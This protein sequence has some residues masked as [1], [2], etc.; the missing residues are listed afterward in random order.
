MTNIDGV[1]IT[2]QVGPRYEE[3]LTDEALRLVAALHSE[4]GGR[5]QELLAARHERQRALAE[6]GTLDFLPETKAL[7]E[8]RSWRVAPPARVSL[9]GASRSPGRPTRR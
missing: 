4:L 6:G 8:D 3:I 7:R 5:R 2:G 1:Q 9:T